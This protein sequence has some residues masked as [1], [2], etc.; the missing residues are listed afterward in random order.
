MAVTIVPIRLQFSTS[1]VKFPDTPVL[2]PE[3][4]A[5]LIAKIAA[6]LAISMFESFA[7]NPGEIVD[8][9]VDDSIPL[10]AA[11]VYSAERAALPKV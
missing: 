7:R 10:A 2:T 8:V 6:K 1:D 11:I 5:E 3:K 9:K 4:R